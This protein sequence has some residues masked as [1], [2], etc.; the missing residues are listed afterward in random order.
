ML[1]DGETT[2][3]QIAASLV[4]GESRGITD[5]PLLAFQP[6]SDNLVTALASHRPPP[7]HLRPPHANSHHLPTHQAKKGRRAP[8]G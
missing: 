5:A 1:L 3:L 2:V 7:I 6:Q 4:I 8:C